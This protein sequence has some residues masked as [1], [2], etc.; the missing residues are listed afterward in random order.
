MRLLLA[1]D[2]ASEGV[3]LHYFCHA[4]AANAPGWTLD[5]PRLSPWPSPDTEWNRHC[6]LR[7]AF[8]RRWA[9][10]EIDAL[11][12]LKLGLTFDAREK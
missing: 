7:N 5:D 12:A 10:V 1:S 3:N 9:P 6:A 8:Q 4:P 2:A 11:A